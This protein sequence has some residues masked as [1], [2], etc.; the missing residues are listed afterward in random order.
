MKQLLKLAGTSPAVNSQRNQLGVG[1]L[2]LVLAVVVVLALGSVGYFV[3][4]KNKDSGA[5]AADKALQQALKNAKCDYDDKDLCKFFTSYKEQKY[6]TVNTTSKSDGKTSNMTLKSEDS[7]KSYFKLNGEVSYEVVTIGQTTYTKAANGTWWKQTAK[8]DTATT[9]KDEASPQLSE[10][11]PTA[12][13]DKITYKKIGTEKCGNLTCFKYQMIDPSDTKTT[14]YLWF[15]NKDYQLRRVQ[16]TSEGSTMDATYSYAKVSI[17]E[18]SPV[19]ELGENQYLMP[20]QSEPTT[21]PASNGTMPS[22]EELRK[23]MEQY[24]QG[25]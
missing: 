13:A 5:T 11:E 9:L 23:L 1:H 3:Y 18:P 24:Q 4:N 22:D 14:S 10:P 17:S 7:D 20:G 25:N 8:N 6:Y 16:T 15:D 19:K 21:L 12:E 2:G